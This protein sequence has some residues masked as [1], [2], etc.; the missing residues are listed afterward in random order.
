MHDTTHSIPDVD[1]PQLSGAH[2][3]ELIGVKRAPRGTLMAAAKQIRQIVTG[4]CICKVCLIQQ[5]AFLHV[6]SLLSGFPRK[7][8]SMKVTSSVTGDGVP[9]E[10]VKIQ[11][12]DGAI[13][14]RFALPS[15]RGCCPFSVGRYTVMLMINERSLRGVV[16]LDLSELV[17]LLLEEVDEIV[18]VVVIIRNDCL[19]KVLERLR[20]FGPIWRRAAPF[21]RT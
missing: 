12:S 9:S 8:Q 21:S 19:N 2:S 3:I 1:P 17:S 11:P 7:L 10:M 16:M 18:E 15:H 14:A 6:V 13:Q 5:L 20:A 4:C